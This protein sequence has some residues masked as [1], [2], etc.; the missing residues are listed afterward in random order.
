MHILEE[1]VEMEV[2]TETTIVEG[3]VVQN[4]EEIPLG[5]Y[6]AKAQLEILGGITAQP[7]EVIPTPLETT[8]AKTQTI[9]LVMNEA[10]C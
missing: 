6:E 5:S 1:M 4:E 8:D 3:V 7:E 9:I 2:Q 10:T